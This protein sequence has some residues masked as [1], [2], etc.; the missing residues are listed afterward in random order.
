MQT[1]RFDRLAVR[2]AT[3]GGVLFISACGGGDVSDVAAGSHQLPAAARTPV[4]VA[5]AEIVASPTVAPTAVPTAAPA[6]VAQRLPTPVA[7]DETLITPVEKV[8]VPHE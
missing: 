6:A 5:A 7:Y 8:G 1:M 3:I 2:L 4:P